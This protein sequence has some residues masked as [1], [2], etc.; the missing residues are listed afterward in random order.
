MSSFRKGQKMLNNVFKFIYWI[1]LGIRK[2]GSVR[3][4]Q[5]RC[6]PYIFPLLAILTV[7]FYCCVE[8]VF[9]FNEVPKLSTSSFYNGNGFLEFG[10]QTLIPPRVDSGVDAFEGG[11]DLA[12]KSSRRGIEGGLMAS[13]EG[14][15]MAHQ[16]HNQRPGDAEKPQITDS[17]C[18][19]KE[20]HLWVAIVC[21]VLTFISGWIA[22]SC[23]IFYT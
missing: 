11:E 19:A 2:I 1:R 5:M 14:K 10:E 4:C 23:F 13:H 20:V 16:S 6:A 18:E 12:A 9:A 21:C 8:C 3:I 22:H 7:I 17:E 15:A